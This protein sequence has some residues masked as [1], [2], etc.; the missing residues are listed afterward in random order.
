MRDHL[1]PAE[2]PLFEDVF[3]FAVDPDRGRPI[4]DKYGCTQFGDARFT[5]L[6]SSCRSSEAGT[7]IRKC[8]P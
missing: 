3:G 6:P 1:W 4:E 8:A 7:L 2:E 5:G